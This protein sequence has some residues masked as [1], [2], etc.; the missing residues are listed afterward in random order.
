MSA[1]FQSRKDHAF[2]QQEIW[3]SPESNKESSDEGIIGVG[4]RFHQEEPLGH[5][6]KVEDSAILIRVHS[7][8]KSAAAE[9]E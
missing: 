9:L 5:A 6:G 1:H 7:T 8:K 3:V 4:T 2:L